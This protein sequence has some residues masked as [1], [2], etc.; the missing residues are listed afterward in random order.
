LQS[1]D[2]SQRANFA[3]NYAKRSTSS[4]LEDLARFFY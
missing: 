1:G 4:D 2:G 3:G